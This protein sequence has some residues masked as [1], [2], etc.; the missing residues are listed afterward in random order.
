MAILHSGTAFMYEVVSSFRI[1]R[2]S[3]QEVFMQQSQQNNKVTL[4]SDGAEDFGMD[5][6]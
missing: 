5:E 1:K 6:L 4:Y 2:P 3:I